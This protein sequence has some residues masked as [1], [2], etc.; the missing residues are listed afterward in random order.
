MSWNCL[1]ESGSLGV[2]TAGEG[3]AGKAESGPEEGRNRA[4]LRRLLT[5]APLV[6]KAAAGRGGRGGQVPR[7]PG[8]AH[9][10]IHPPTGTGSQ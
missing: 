4:L 2:R 3:A 9:T 5:P 8:W 10:L 6:A 7:G 1:L